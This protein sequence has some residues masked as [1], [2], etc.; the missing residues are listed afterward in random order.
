MSADLLIHGWANDVA[1]HLSLSLSLTLSLS[2]SFALSLALSRSLALFLSLSLSLSPS[3][4]RRVSHAKSC[5]IDYVGQILPPIGDFWM[6][7][8]PVQNLGAVV[9]YKENCITNTG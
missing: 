1:L 2:L 5:N 4:S 7:L 8:A 6:I 3:L 9:L